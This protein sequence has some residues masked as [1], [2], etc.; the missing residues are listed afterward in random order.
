MYFTYL[1]NLLFSVLNSSVYDDG[2]E[3]IAANIVSLFSPFAFSKGKYFIKFI[4]HIK[5]CIYLN[6]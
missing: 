4:T 1:T 6:L 2:N 5:N 3:A